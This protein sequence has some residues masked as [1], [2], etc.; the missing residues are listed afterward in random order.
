MVSGTPRE[1][2][3]KLAPAD[4]FIHVEDFDSLEELAERLN[5][6]IDP[7]NDAEYMKYHAWRRRLDKLPEEGVLLTTLTEYRSSGMCQL[8]QEAWEMKNE[9]RTR[10]YGVVEDLHT[11]WYGD[12][13]DFQHTNMTGI[14]M[15]NDRPDVKY[16]EWDEELV[17]SR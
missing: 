7:A 13:A 8:C 9:V 3:E 10:D 15:V 2:Y 6:L 11:W 17:E 5:F 1:D 4:S 16:Y 12:R 14:C